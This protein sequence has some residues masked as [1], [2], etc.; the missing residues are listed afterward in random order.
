MLTVLMQGG[1]VRMLAPRLGEAALGALGAVAYA[2][3][4][5]LV[6]I[7]G[8]N[9][10]LIGGGLALAGIGMGAFSPCASAL[11]SRQS[12]GDDHGAVMGTYQASTSLARVIGPF[13]SGYLYQLIGTNAPFYTG[14]CLALP[15]AWLL[16]RARRGGHDLGARAPASASAVA[17]SAASAATEPVPSERSTRP[18]R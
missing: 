1:F 10:P 8:R 9:V 16:W 11:A 7:A 13:A 5:I 15:A 18:D 6:G 17:A 4:L 3:G 2:I 12:H 14:A